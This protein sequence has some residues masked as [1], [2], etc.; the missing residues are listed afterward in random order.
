[1]RRHLSVAGLA[2]QLGSGA[3]RAECDDSQNEF[4]GVYCYA[5]VYIESDNDLNAA[6]KAITPT[7]A[8][9]PKL[10]RL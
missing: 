5:R 4:D 1:M 2:L 3:A 9:E 8:I 6:Y 7:I 10:M